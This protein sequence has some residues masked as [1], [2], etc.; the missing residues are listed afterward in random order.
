MTNTSTRLVRLSLA[1]AA[2]PFLLAAADS[3]RA[4]VDENIAE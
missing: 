1:A 3:P 2:I 4:A